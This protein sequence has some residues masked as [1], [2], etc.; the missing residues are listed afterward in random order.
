M[1]SSMMGMLERRGGLLLALALLVAGP[2]FAQAPVTYRVT[3]PEPEHHWMQVEV[4]FAGLGNRPLQA[5]MSRSSP[6]RYAV[7]EFAKN[8]FAVDAFNGKGAPLAYTRP[9]PYQ[10]NV[11]GHDGTVRLVY[12]IF[13]D[14]GDGTYFAVDTT[15]ARLNIPATLMWGL[16]LEARPARVTFVP[17]ANST[18]KVATQLFPA[19]EPFTF[20]APNL[21]YLMDSPAELSDFG[22]RTF[23]VKNESTAKNPN[24]KTFEIRLAVHHDGTDADLDALAKDV[25][26]VVTEQAAV[27]G[28]YP[29]FDTGQYTFLLDYTPHSDGDGMEHRNSTFTSSRLTIADPQQRRNAL[30]T[31]SHEFFH[32]WNVER[33]RPADLEP[34]N[35]TDAN[36]SCCL[37]L[38]EGFTQYY[39]NLLLI[40]AGM[41][42]QAQGGASFGGSVNAVV[43]GSGRQVR[44]AV[45]MSQHAPYT[46]AA[47]AIDRTDF[48]RTFISYYTY[49]AA[50]ALALD[51]SLREMSKGELT[52]DHYMR[53]LWTVHGKPAGSAPGLV[54]KPYTLKDLRDRLAELTKN[55]VFA[56]EFF[57]KYIE[58]RDV[59]AYAPLLAQA[60]YVLRPRAPEA[61]WIGNVRVAAVDG[62]LAINPPQGNT[63]T[64]ID[65]G[66]PAYAAGLEYG[67]V[68]TAIDGQPATV[69]SF[70]AFSRRKPGESAVLTVQRRGRQSITTTITLKPNPALV[71][72]PIE[73]DG[74]ALTDAQ[75]AFREQ[76]L[77]TKVK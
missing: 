17:P 13:G 41:A 12:K 7:H 10:W 74:T 11:A 28:E 35:F 29:Q 39:G 54:A 65:F 20:T 18:W 72:L 69:D 57:S 60:G 77:G 67:D 15:H 58:G 55:R 32:A 68:I 14:R 19:S 31:I 3:F 38:A 33:I 22:L 75:K 27:F 26:R 4:T 63:V 47:A 23:T 25:E 40:R 42:P 44:S 2:A 30:S 5:R 51:L 21:Q 62:G 48:G 36:V 59:A 64:P 9:T 37:W 34:F 8:I 16:G 6:G 50:V 53:A 46:D 66:T 70:G 56:D 1:D 52:L 71:V 45:E 24:G 73:A 61:G 76:W 43:T 49:G